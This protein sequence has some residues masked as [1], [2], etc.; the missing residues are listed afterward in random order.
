MAAA[1]VAAVTGSA[2]RR[3]PATSRIAKAPSHHPSNYSRPSS[4]RRPRQGLFTVVLTEKLEDRRPKKQTCWFRSN[5]ILSSPL[6]CL[7]TWAASHLQPAYPCF[8]LTAPSD[9]GLHN[10]SGSVC[11]CAPDG[12]FRSQYPQSYVS[13]TIGNLLSWSDC[14]RMPIIKWSGEMQSNASIKRNPQKPQAF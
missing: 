11:W 4:K 13:L 3:S 8:P 5:Y 1:F 12:Q 14:G 7:L 2:R 10:Y 6:P 9:D